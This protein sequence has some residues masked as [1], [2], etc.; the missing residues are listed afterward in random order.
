[1]IAAG[2][3]QDDAA[4]EI[5][6]CL[7]CWHFVATEDGRL[8]IQPR[9]PVLNLRDFCILL[10]RLQRSSKNSRTSVLVLHFDD[11][12]ASRSMWRIVFRL[13]AAY[14]KSTGMDCRVIRSIDHRK[15]ESKDVE[16]TAEVVCRRAAAGPRQLI[17]VQSVSVVIRSPV[18]EA[19]EGNTN[20]R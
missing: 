13:L 12:Q 6:Q 19:V 5:R 2:R 3:R 14:A 18:I 9:Q 15:S 10:K 20:Q 8:W 4:H 17:R 16:R 1:M 11:V 7:M